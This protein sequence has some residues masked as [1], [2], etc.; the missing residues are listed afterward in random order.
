MEALA[1]ESQVAHAAGGDA[2]SLASAA[3]AE[4]GLPLEALIAS[5]APALVPALHSAPLNPHCFYT[6]D[7]PY[8]SL[9]ALSDAD[10]AAAWRLADY[11]MLVEC[12]DALAYTVAQREVRKRTHEG[13]NELVFTPGAVFGGCC[14][15]QLSACIACFAIL[16]RVFERACSF[17]LFFTRP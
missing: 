7:D 12:Q 1:R 6:R 3:A 14:V 8:P 17:F 9:A 2:A 11:L 4:L 13:T 15:L 5:L 16:C 10:L